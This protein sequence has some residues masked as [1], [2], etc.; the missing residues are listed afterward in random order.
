[1]FRLETNAVNTK[2]IVISLLAVGF[3]LIF[4]K[5]KSEVKNPNKY[6]PLLKR[7]SGNF[8]T[9]SGIA[10]KAAAVSSKSKIKNSE[11]VKVNGVTVEDAIIIDL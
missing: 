9:I 10:D 3:A 4:H 5:N 1:M 2:K 8:K 7:V 6:K 11:P